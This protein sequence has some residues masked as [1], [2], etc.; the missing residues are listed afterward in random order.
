MIIH[1]KKT[2]KNQ[3][4]TERNTEWI[5][6]R[7][8]L[9]EQTKSHLYKVLIIFLFYMINHTKSCGMMWPSLFVDHVKKYISSTI[10]E[11]WAKY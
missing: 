7:I 9:K 8:G 11:R 6:L 10:V 5:N 2:N 4:N 1:L 3:K